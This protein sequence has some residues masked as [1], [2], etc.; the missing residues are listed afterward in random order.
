MCGI[1][2]A[3]EFNS[4][5][6]ILNSISHRGIERTDKKLEGVTL[7]HHRLP[8]QTVE[9]DNWYQPK[10][11][12]DGIYMLF[13]GEIFNYDTSAYSSDIEYLCNLFSSYSF[14]G[15]EMFSALFLPHMQTWDGFWA[16][17][18]YDSKTG[19]AICF[20]DPLGK[21]CLY[22][23]KEGEISSEIKGVYRQG[24]SIDDTYISSV[25]KWGYNTDNR[26]PYKE[27][28]RI[29][30]NNIY[31]FN[32]GSPMFQQV[33]QKYWEGFDSPIYELRG[34]SYEEHMEWLWD[35]MVESVKNRL[36]SK[37]YPISALISGGLDSSIIAALM[38]SESIDRINWFTIENGETEYVDLLAKHLDI[39]VN[40]LTY[41]MDESLNKEIY[42]IWNEGPVDLGSVIPQYHL[43][44]AVKEQTGYRIVISGDGSDEL[45]GG[46]SRIH[47]FDS[48]KSDVFEEL[49]YYHLPRLDK[50]SMAHTLELR[51]PFLNLDIVRFALH[52]PLEWRKDKK[53]LK[54]TFSPILP[55]EIVVRKKIPLK[56]PQIKEDKI[57]YRQKA[58][59]LF[60]SEM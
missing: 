52:L 33:Y 32:I 25:R 16:I 9:G 58:I 2:L 22:V 45:F 13:N 48:Q 23:N 14:G 12:S 55:P 30:P 18:I 41:D 4:T 60:L 56:N 10:Q 28:K 11:I 27:I 29:L 26:T 20:T 17:V 3:T 57:A 43:F 19:D 51:T 54:D 49:S 24:Y 59:D 7:C 39:K 38:K 6:E 47:E 46:Y 5:E 35:K 53:I 8:I 44:K 37:N 50:M 36:L 1:I 21:K 15:V 42:K 34:K 31:S 40:K